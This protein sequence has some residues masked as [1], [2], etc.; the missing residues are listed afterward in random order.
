VRVKMRL[1]TADCKECQAKASRSLIVH[2]RGVFS[3][4]KRCVSPRWEW[5]PTEDISVLKELAK[6]YH[7]P[8]GVL[9]GAVEKAMAPTPVRLVVDLE[10]T[11]E[12]PFE[13]VFHYA[14]SGA[15]VIILN[16]NGKNLEE[17][18]EEVIAHETVHCVIDRIFGEAPLAYVLKI[19]K[20]WDMACAKNLE[21]KEFYEEKYARL[22]S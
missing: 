21:T 10:V 11:D 13:S 9:L 1:G 5:K 8:V 6:E 14:T 15:G 17:R 19:H 7:V 20:L 16:P 18:V 4:C 22:T 2:R 12:Y 3:D